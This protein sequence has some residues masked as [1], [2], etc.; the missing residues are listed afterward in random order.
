VGEL[1]GQSNPTFMVTSG[2]GATYT[3]RKQPPGK[4]LPGA[5]AV[6]REYQVM[7]A[8]GE[9]L[10]MMSWFVGDIF[11]GGGTRSQWVNFIC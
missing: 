5:H 10:L 7:K 6:D 8:L 9:L 11:R 4:L 2:D 1:I 3:V